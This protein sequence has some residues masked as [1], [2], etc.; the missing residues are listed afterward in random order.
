[1]TSPATNPTLDKTLTAAYVFLVVLTFP[2]LSAALGSSLVLSF[3]VLVVGVGLLLL[4]VRWLFG[5]T[6]AFVSRVLLPHT[7]GTD[8]LSKAR[9]R[10]KFADQGWQL[11]VHV[12][13]A[14]WEWS[15]L[16]D[17]GFL[18]DPDLTMDFTQQP[19]TPG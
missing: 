16:Q 14:L 18:T 12:G 10:Q 6:G 3:P 2:T 19:T 1:M 17:F 9:G 5:V 11:F 13:F 4:T 8:P 15:L 7:L